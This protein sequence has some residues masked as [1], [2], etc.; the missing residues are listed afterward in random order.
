MYPLNLAQTRPASTLADVALPQTY[1][2]GEKSY[3][4]GYLLAN[5]QVGRTQAALT[6]QKGAAQSTLP[7]NKWSRGCRALKSQ[8]L[9]CAWLALL[10]PAQKRQKKPS[11][12]TSLRLPANPS[13][14][15]NTSNLIGRVLLALVATPA[16]FPSAPLIP[17][18]KE[19]SAC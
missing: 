16:L 15:V 8:F 17:F 12:L 6:S 13:I 14:P 4:F 3:H 19:G 7:Q 2:F 5:V 9:P 18:A 11:M 10:P 1:P